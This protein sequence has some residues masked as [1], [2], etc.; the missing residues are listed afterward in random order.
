MTTKVLIGLYDN[1][2]SPRF[3]LCS[4]VLIVQIDETEG[5]AREEKLVV[6]SQASAEMLC[7]MVLTEAIQVVVCG[8][9]EDEYYQYLIWKRVKVLD[10]IIGDVKHALEQLIRGNLK[11]GDILELSEP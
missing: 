9:I 7:H 8:G 6:L 4:E 5:I 11:S 2:V 1:E 10:S 3:D